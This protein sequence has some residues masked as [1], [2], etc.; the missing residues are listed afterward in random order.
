HW[1][2]SK[3]PSYTKSV[4]WQHHPTNK[5]LLLCPEEIIKSYRESWKFNP[6]NT[7]EFDAELRQKLQKEAAYCIPI[8]ATAV[9]RW[10]I[11]SAPMI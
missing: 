9:K 3:T 8:S 6:L 2:T 5:F 1:S 10:D 7:A 4:S 11:L